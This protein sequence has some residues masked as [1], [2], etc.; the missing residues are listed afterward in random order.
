MAAL[1]DSVPSPFPEL[2]LGSHALRHL[3][4]MVDMSSDGRRGDWTSPALTDSLSSMN[5]SPIAP[6]PC[7]PTSPMVRVP[8][9]A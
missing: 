3:L 6:I 2:S 9:S 4:F 1:R 8:C 5:L 7:G